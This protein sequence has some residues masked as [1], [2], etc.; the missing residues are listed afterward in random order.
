MAHSP[1]TLASGRRRA[2]GRDGLTDRQRAI[3]TVIADHT[4]ARGYPPTMREIGRAVGLSSSSSVAHQINRLQDLGHVEADPQRPR[5][6]R[7][8][9][10]RPAAPA[11]PEHGSVAVPLLSPT[12]ADGPLAAGHDADVLHLPRR[13]VGDGELVALTIRGASSASDGAMRDGDLVMV[14]R[15]P[16]ADDDDLVAVLIDGETTV[17]R[18]RRDGE[19]TWFV[20][21]RTAHRP[22]SGERAT[23]I[24]KVVAVLR[25][26]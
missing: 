25:T 9:T 6:Y 3:L 15:Q 10:T 11:G 14:R 7:L 23:V 19:H 20:P 2:V 1:G 5:T 22:V 24:G 17:S 8:T 4:T 16:T 13:I 21:H 26:V 18:Y 12:E